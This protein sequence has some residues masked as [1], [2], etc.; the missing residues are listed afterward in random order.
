MMLSFRS[1]DARIQGGENCEGR[2]GDGRDGSEKTPPV[3]VKP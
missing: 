1:S 3:M 2:P